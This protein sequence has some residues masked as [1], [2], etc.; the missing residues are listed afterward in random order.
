MIVC[1]IE[2]CTARGGRQWMIDRHNRE[3]HC[4]CICGWTG[5]TASL[6]QHQGQRRRHHQAAGQTDPVPNH[7]AAYH[8]NPDHHYQPDRDG[9]CCK[10]ACDESCADGPC[11]GETP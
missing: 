2:G 1:P 9:P 6:G 5:L 10:P 3:P 11:P 4:R 7:V 8:I